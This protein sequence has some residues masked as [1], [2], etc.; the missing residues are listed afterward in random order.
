MK[1]RPKTIEVQNAAKTFQ[2]EAERL[3][4]LDGDDAIMWVNSQPRRI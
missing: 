2:E 1:I 4:D 3:Q